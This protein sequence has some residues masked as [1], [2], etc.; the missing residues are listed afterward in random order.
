MARI[1]GVEIEDKLKVDYA[2][3]KIKGIGW[4]LSKK[5]LN[6]LKIDP[7]KRL[8][9][10]TSDQIAKIASKMEEHSTEGDLIRKVRE[11]IS[12]LRTTGSYR[13]MRHTKG[14][15]VRGQRTRTNARTK[16]GKR[17]TVGA[18][19]KEALTKVQQKGKESE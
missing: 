9:E 12:R 18:F 4:A 16:R 13:G 6:S 1:A 17:K 14:L 2:L 10:L 11:D 5:I 3:T 15:P 7:S 8:S 19:R